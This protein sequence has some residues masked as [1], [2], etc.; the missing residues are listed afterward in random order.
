VQIVDST[1]VINPAY[2]S[3]AH[4]AGTFAKVFVHPTAREEL[5][6]GMDVEV[7]GGMREHRIWERARSEIWRI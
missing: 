7:D 1:L 3:R 5:E 2:L 4:S 6:N